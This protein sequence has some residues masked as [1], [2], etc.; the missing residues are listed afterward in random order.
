MALVQLPTF[1]AAV[2]V[3]SLGSGADQMFVSAADAA[4]KKYLRW[5]PELVTGTVKYLD[6]SGVN[7]IVMPGLPVSLSV[8]EI[9]VDGAGGWGQIPDTFGTDTVLTLG[10]NYLVD[11][12]CGILRMRQPLTNGWWW[13]M[14][15]GGSPQGPTLYW[16]GLRNWG[17]TPAYWPR[18]PGC[19]KVTYTNGYAAIPA[20]LQMAV[21]ELAAWLRRNAKLGGMVVNSESWNGDSYSLDAMQVEAYG[22]LQ[23]PGLG[24]TRQ[25]LAAYREPIVPT[26]IRP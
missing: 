11:Y 5:N 6:G 25:L 9:R 1:Q 17:V 2:G 23:M 12:A 26:G 7:E 10:T 22:A 15:P 24:T 16:G 3:G 13:A 8:S 20:D 19:V 21:I 4:V 18:I 14:P